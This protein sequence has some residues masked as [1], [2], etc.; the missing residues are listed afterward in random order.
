MKTQILLT[1]E[2]KKDIPNLLDKVAGRAYT[3]TGVD[4]VTVEQLDLSVMAINGVISWFEPQNA[5]PS[6]FAKNLY[7]ISVR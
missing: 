2:H 1:I 4:D 5:K 6:D 3:L 7:L